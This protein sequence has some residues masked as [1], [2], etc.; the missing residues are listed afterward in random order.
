MMVA[1]LKSTGN[2]LRTAVVPAKV[3]SSQP[4]VGAGI[5]CSRCRNHLHQGKW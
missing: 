5:T 1:G 2:P 3:Q 4:V